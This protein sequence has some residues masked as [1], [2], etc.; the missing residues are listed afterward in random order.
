MLNRLESISCDDSDGARAVQYQP[1]SE[2]ITPA[3]IAPLLDSSKVKAYERKLEEDEQ[4]S[5]KMLKR[6]R[7]TE[8][9][10][11][12]GVRAKYKKEFGQQQQQS[13]KHGTSTVDKLLKNGCKRKMTQS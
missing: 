11:K 5:A 8:A 10:A 1:I 3:H 13:G 6:K 4:L 12:Q 9:L 7:I 2:W